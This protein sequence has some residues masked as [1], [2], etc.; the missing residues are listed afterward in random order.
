[1]VVSDVVET[2]IIT[3]SLLLSILVSTLVKMDM[4]WT[5]HSLANAHCG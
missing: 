4:G 1:M 3:N 5:C 2:L